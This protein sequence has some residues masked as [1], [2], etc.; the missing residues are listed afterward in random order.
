M[1]RF[2]CAM[3]LMAPNNGDGTGGGGGG[4]TPAPP[5]PPAPP[6][7]PA[8]P[9]ADPPPAA[10][11]TFPTQEAFNQRLEQAARSRLRELGLP[12][13]PAKVK[14]AL[15]EAERL[16]KEE[17]ERKK[18][19]LTESD[20]LKAEAAEAQAKAAAAEAQAAAARSELELTRLCAG[21]GIKDIAYAQFRLAS[22]KPENPEAWLK[23]QLASPVER[24]RFGLDAPAAPGGTPGTPPASTTTTQP[25]AP[26]PAPGGPGQPAQKDAMQMTPKEYAE[27]KRQR[28]GGN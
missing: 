14:E 15:A 8:N 22:Q 18:A 20:R 21:L 26:P 2:M 12:E 23:E 16:R 13:D 27:Y 1:L 5:T 17:S 19:Q 3:A 7:P 25:G 28:Y 4:N 11:I 24:T 9:P 10:P 6:A